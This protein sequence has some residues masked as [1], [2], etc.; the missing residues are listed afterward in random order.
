MKLFPAIDILDGRAVRLLYGK[1]E[2]VTDYGLPLERAKLW[3]DA[4]A[5][6]LHVVDLSGAFEGTSQINR[7]I[8][9]IAAL[10]VKVQSGGGLRTMQSI[11]DRLNA[12]AARV[13]LGTVAV[14]DPELFRTAV[15]KYGDR[16]VAGIDCRNGFVSV[17]GWTEESG[18]TGAEFGRRAKALG[19]T[20]CVFTD[21][22]RDG[23][24]K[25]P[26]VRATAELARETG[27]DVIASGGISTMADLDELAAQ[28]VYGAILGR[29]V[30][31]GTIDLK[32]AIGRFGN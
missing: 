21:V 12:G 19:V 4:G 8:E 28:G 7:E 10:G 18:E 27:L 11:S 31:E 3:K 6:F 9:K 25:G 24:L 23:A 29:S 14:T 1:R 15:E 17:R 20:C 5:E 2:E 32:E 26:A 13:V 16:I 30:Y 22:S